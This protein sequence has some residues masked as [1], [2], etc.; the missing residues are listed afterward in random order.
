MLKKTTLVIMAIIVSISLVA[1]SN[2]VSTNPSASPITSSMEPTE[3]Q[4]IVEK[5]DLHLF[6]GKI[7]EINSSA[8]VVEPNE[9]TVERG[10]ADKI[11][12]NMFKE[13]SKLS[14][15]DVIRVEY[16]GDIQET[17]PASITN[18][19]SIEII[20]KSVKPRMIYLN[21]MLYVDSGRLTEITGRCGVMDFE[22]TSTVDETEIPSVNNQSN[23]GTG[24]EGQYIDG[25]IEIVINDDW[26]VF[27]PQ[28]LNDI[29][30]LPRVDAGAQK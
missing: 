8:I 7:V 16:E 4:N 1:C 25:N 11:N 12:L 10:I 6:D 14:L 28:T 23:F 9:G 26:C 2:K 13:N 20:E 29:C 24:Y 17:Y 19:N 30:S 22:I 18:V 5:E 15:D 3:T 27:E 21:D